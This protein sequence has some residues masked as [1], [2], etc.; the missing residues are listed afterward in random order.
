MSLIE[1]LPSVRELTETDKRALM[2][3]L[4]SQL[5]GSERIPP[6]SENFEHSTWSPHDSHEAASQLS[7]LLNETKA[8]KK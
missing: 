8:A 1:L 2:R 7:A 5:S 3:W 4:E 6:L